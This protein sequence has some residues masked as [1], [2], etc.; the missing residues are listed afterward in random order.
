MQVFISNLYEDTRHF[1][2]L[3]LSKASAV[4]STGVER[5]RDNAQYLPGDSSQQSRGRR[6]NAFGRA[7]SKGWPASS[8]SSSS[9]EKAVKWR[10]AGWPS[11]LSASTARTWI[12]RKIIHY[13]Q[14][15]EG[16]CVGGRCCMTLKVCVCFWRWHSVWQNG[17]WGSNEHLI[18]GYSPLLSHILRSWLSVP[19]NEAS[20]TP[21]ELM[22]ACQPVG[23]N[24]YMIHVEIF[25]FLRVQ[26]ILQSPCVFVC[27]FAW[28][29]I[30]CVVLGLVHTLTV[31]GPIFLQGT[32]VQ[33]PC[34]ALYLRVKV[35]L[36]QGGIKLSY[37]DGIHGHKW[38]DITLKKI[39][40]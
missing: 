10:D 21:S 34:S 33:R 1:A 35:C 38:N 15:A 5:F 6:C 22:P 7:L 19:D 25:I 11:T 16:R 3:R 28:V 8:R 23:E 20:V 40:N 12:Y 27:Q 9:N 32:H 37:S 39:M 2:C 13:L 30:Y 18:L 24:V 17:R 36:F 31:W 14:S 29:F 4:M 26:V